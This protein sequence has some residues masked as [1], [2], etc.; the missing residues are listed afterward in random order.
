ML[1]KL[2]ESIDKNQ[3]NKTYG[4]KLGSL[5]AENRQLVKNGAIA[6]KSICASCHGIEGQGLPN[7]MAPPL[8]GGFQRVS[9]RKEET[10]KI[11]LHGLTGPVDGQHY[12]EMMPPMGSSDDEWIASVLSYLRYDLGLASVGTSGPVHP[13]YAEKILVKPEEVKKI[14]QETAGR[15]KPYT[16]AELNAE[17]EKAK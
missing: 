14:R 8:V 12:N 15:K 6:F 7:K 11:L 3:Q 17:N 5:D 9:G 4:A 1:G 16:W 10:I 2:P 13:G